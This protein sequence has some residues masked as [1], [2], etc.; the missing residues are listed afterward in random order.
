MESHARPTE[1]MAAWV[2]RN[3]LQT[4]NKLVNKFESRVN[5]YIVSK[6]GAASTAIVRVR[7]RVHQSD[8]NSPKLRLDLV[9][10]ASPSVVVGDRNIMWRKYCRDNRCRTLRELGHKHSLHYWRAHYITGFP[11]GILVPVMIIGVVD[12]GSISALKRFGCAFW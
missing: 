6:L 11:L 3:G 12:K 4:I 2:Q 5:T 9:D 10:K 8:S 7:K 1:K